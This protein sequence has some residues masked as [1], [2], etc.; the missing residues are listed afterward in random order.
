MKELELYG[1]FYDGVV[2]A[3]IKLKK[4]NIKPGI[5]SDAQFYTPIDLTLLTRKQS[6]NMLDDYLELFDVDLI[7]YSYE[8]GM[9]KANPTLFQKLYDTLYEYQILPSQTVFVGNDLFL[10]IKPAADIGMRTAFFAGDD[11]SAFVHDTGGEIIPDIVF[12][13]WDELPEK[14]SF[15]KD[16]SNV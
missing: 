11:K 13:S 12:D 2:D 4:G 14:I 9:T 7:Y 1:D 15:F 8:Y 10:D 5:V 3:L 16:K 6:N